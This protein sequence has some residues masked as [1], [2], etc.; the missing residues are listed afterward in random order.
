MDRRDGSGASAMTFINEG[1]LHNESMVDGLKEQPLSASSLRELQNGLPATNRRYDSAYHNRHYEDN[2]R[3]IISAGIREYACENLGERTARGQPQNPTKPKFYN[4]CI[5]F[6]T[7]VLL[8]AP[9]A[10]SAYVFIKHERFVRCDSH[11]EGK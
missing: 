4:C 3:R 2:S 5:I 7:I 11:S 10:I 1:F 9:I 8:L 6:S